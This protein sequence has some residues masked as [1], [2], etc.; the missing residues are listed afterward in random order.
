MILALALSGGCIAYEAGGRHGL[1]PAPPG[2]QD[3]SDYKPDQP[4]SLSKPGFAE[5]S[6]YSSTASSE[7][8]G[9]EVR[10]YLVAPS[11]PDE[12][13]DLEG[14]AVLE[15]REGTG[16]AFVGER[17]VELHPGVVFTADVGQLLRV[18]AS[19][20]PLALRIWIVAAR[21]AP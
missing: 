11:L 1:P 15:V 3:F 8:Y 9:V 21:T 13:L 16:E 20:K 18:I 19:G 5:R 2:T 14:G 7:G 10:D 6:I 12:T 17:R 4:Y